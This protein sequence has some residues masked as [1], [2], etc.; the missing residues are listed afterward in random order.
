MPSPDYNFYLRLFV[1]LNNPEITMIR[2][3]IPNGPVDGIGRGSDG[4]DVG[5]TDGVYVGFGVTVG[6]G[7]MVGTG[8]RLTLTPLGADRDDM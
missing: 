2:N 6:T 3:P 5:V 4:V 8:I 1:I 7:V